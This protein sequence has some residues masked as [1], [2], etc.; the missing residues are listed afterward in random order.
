MLDQIMDLVKGQVAKSVG[1]IKGIP[2]GKES[3]VVETTADS[4]LAGLKKNASLDGLGA[5]LGGGVGGSMVSGLSSGVVKALTS[6]LKLSPAV[7]QTI[8]STVIPAVTSLLKNKVDDKNE[9]GFNLESML[10]N[11][12]GGGGKASSGGLGGL[13]GGL[14][15]LF[16]KK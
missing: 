11:L 15:G 7:A 1:G 12:V 14:G 8:A 10:G 2:A 16:G 3:A 9:P 5:L 13:L 6:K 4:L